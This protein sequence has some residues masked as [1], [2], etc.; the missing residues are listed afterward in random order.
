MRAALAWTLVAAA[1]AGAASAALPPPSP[2]QA[3]AAAAKKAAADAQAQKEKQELLASMD[4]I[5]ARWRAKAGS[6]G[7]RTNPPVAVAAPAAA[8][9]A[10]AT[11]AAPAGQPGGTQGN[12]P[13]LPIRSEKAGTAP[14]SADVKK[15]P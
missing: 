8:V 5:T 15:T 10:P 7:L 14:P 11:A 4:G 12:A 1:A 6:R 3:Q 9:A 2:A 13:A